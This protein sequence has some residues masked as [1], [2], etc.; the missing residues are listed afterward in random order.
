MKYKIYHFIWFIPVYLLLQ[1]IY[2]IYS[3][4]GFIKTYDHG[5]SY[6][7]SVN[8]LQIKNLQAQTN[9][10]IR[11]SFDTK[12]GEH[13][14]RQMTVPVNVAGMVQNYTKIPVRY[15]KASSEPVVMIPTYNFQRHIF[16]SN[17]G[18]LAISFFIALGVAIWVERHFWLENRGLKPAGYNFEI[19][20]HSPA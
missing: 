12:D 18:I 5:T 7:A 10:V 13:I 16:L 17:M 8:Y 20:D 14:D 6:I 1:G 2:Q 19:I 9:G 11:L 15:L 4:N 3:Y